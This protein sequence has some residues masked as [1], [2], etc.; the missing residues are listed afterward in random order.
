MGAPVGEIC[1]LRDLAWKET[2]TVS[3]CGGA[4][5]PEPVAT[6]TDRAKAYAFAL[7]ERDRRRESGAELAVHFPDDCPC[8]GRTDD[9][10]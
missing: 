2:W 4:G 8:Y 3:I 5:K 1:V 7:A 9:G 6:F 10:G